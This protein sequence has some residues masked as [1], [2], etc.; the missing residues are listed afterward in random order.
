MEQTTSQNK[1]VIERITTLAEHRRLLTRVFETAQERVIVVSP[2][3]SS[4]AIKADGVHSLVRSATR[5]GVDVSVYTDD[6][7][8][9]DVNGNIKTAAQ[10][11]MAHLLAAGARVNIVEGFHNKTIAKDN[12]MIAEGSFNWLSAVRDPKS[13]LHRN[14]R[15]LVYKGE[16]VGEMINHEI[17][18]LQRKIKGEATMLKTKRYPTKAAQKNYVPVVLLIVLIFAAMGTKGIIAFIVILL[19][20]KGLSFA[21]APPPAAIKENRGEKDNI[22]EADSELNIPNEESTVEQDTGGLSQSSSNYWFFWN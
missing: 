21:F 10:K 3:I 19:V 18:T 8:N 17:E 2:F 1:T 15:T 14:E 11:G 13:S 22:E 7:L 9:K 6:M 5:R 16:N 12:D 20:I 4:S